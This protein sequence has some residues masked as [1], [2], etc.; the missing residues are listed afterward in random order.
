MSICPYLDSSSEIPDTVCNS[1]LH[2]NNYILLLRYSPVRAR[3]LQPIASLTFTCPQT[4]LKDHT[5]S[6][7]V[8]F[9]QHVESPAVVDFLDRDYY[10]R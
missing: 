3:V 10:Y 5:G 4:E 1:Y 6:L 2:I 8:T 7:G 9:V